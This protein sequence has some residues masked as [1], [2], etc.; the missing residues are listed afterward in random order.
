[1]VV[2]SSRGCS[3]WTPRFSPACGRS[4]SLGL[5]RV[6]GSSVPYVVAS[7]LEHLDL[8]D[9]E[10]PLARA[11][12]SFQAYW[13]NLSKLRCAS[14]CLDTALNLQVY[15]NGAIAHHLRAKLVSKECCEAWD[16]AVLSF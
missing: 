11:R 4:P 13:Q 7:E 12:D 5:V 9:A 16:E 6:L 1:M 8:L 2:R 15:V 10:A 3:N 14:L